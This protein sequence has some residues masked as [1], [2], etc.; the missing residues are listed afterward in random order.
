MPAAPAPPAPPDPPTLQIGSNGE[1]RLTR[2]SAAGKLEV[3]YRGD[4]MLTGDERDVQA[5]SPNGYLILSDGGWVGARRLE[6]RADARGTITRVFRSGLRERPYE[7]EG[8]QFLAD[9]LPKLLETGFAARARVSLLLGRGGPAAVLQAIERLDTDY[10]RH[11]YYRELLTQATLDDAALSQA[12]T[13]AA[14]QIS[15]A[16]E[17]AELLAGATAQ[18]MAGPMSRQAYFKMAS[19]ITSDYEKRRALRAPLARATLDGEALADLLGVAAGIGSDY[20]LAE[21]LIEV[22]GLRPLGATTRAPFFRAVESIASDHE[23][24]RVLTAVQRQAGQGG[25]SGSRCSSRRRDSPPTTSRRNSCSAGSGSS[26]SRPPP[27]GSSS[28]PGRSPPTTTA[29]ACSQPSRIERRFRRP[30]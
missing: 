7:P 1:G 14:S 30:S 24:R 10:A 3:R 13:S 8:R 17:S 23:H 6:L 18:A 2:T 15:S 20:E 25:T 19:G 5:I 28:E 4:L 22:A 26:P 9:M 29:L 11:V 16:Y 21:L 27:S 12:L